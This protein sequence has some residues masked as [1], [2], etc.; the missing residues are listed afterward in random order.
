MKKLLNL[1]LQTAS[2]ALARRSARP[3]ALAN[4]L[5]GVFDH[6]RETLQID[7]STSLPVAAKYLVYKRGSAQY[8]AAVAD[9]VN[10]PLGISPDAAYQLGD[11]LDIERLGATFGTVLGYSA[12]AVTIDD[13]VYSAANGLAGDLTTA[14]HGTFWVIGRAVNSVSAASQEITFVPCFPYQVTQ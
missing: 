13:L 12:G 10:M 2:F 7:P 3:V 1:I 5:G 6:G 11:F 14:G 9:G 4:Q 8:Y